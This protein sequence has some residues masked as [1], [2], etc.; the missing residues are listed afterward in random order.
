MTGWLFVNGVSKSNNL[1]ANIRNSV[2]PSLEGSTMAELRAKF[3]KAGVCSVA[4]P[5]PKGVSMLTY[6]RFTNWPFAAKVALAPVIGLAL[7]LVISMIT[8]QSL[9]AQSASIRV[10]IEQTTVANSLLTEASATIQ[11][12]NGDLYKVLTRT[13]A[14]TP[15]LNGEAEL[16]AISGRLDKVVALLTNFRDR[17]AD[18][19]EKSKI[20]DTIAAV[21]KYK[22]GFKFVS[23]MLDID[24]QSVVNFLDPFDKLAAGVTS[25]LDHIIADANKRSQL[26][27]DEVAHNAKRTSHVSHILAMIQ[28]IIV[29][30]ATVALATTTVRS[31]RRI[32]T[33]TE[34]LAQGDTSIDIDSLARRD[35]LGAIVRSL[36]TFRASQIQVKTLQQEQVEASRMAAE[37]RRTLMLNLADHFDQNVRSVVDAVAATARDMK[38][39]STILSHT[40]ADASREANAVAEVS[41]DATA[42][43]HSV[44]AASTQLS[45]SIAE[46]S[47]QVVNSSTIASNAV[48]EASS[49]RDQVQQL[50]AAAHKIGDIVALIQGIA[51]QTNLLALNATIEAARAGEAGRGFAV[52]AAEVKSLATE[53]SRATSEISSHVNEIQHATDTTVGAI[54]RIGATIGNMS[55]IAASIAA[56][57]EEQ[58]AATVEISR[59]AQQV[60]LA[61]EEVAQR[62]ISVSDA[63]VATGEASGGVLDASNTLA[64]QADTLNREVGEFLATVRA[65]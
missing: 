46:I 61:T 34:A 20:S 2:T 59:I 21:T 41:G 36:A 26:A 7:L 35:E 56:A 19:Q 48:E 16:A 12:A 27:A 60:A 24:F 63:A 55:E 10:L 50:A 47:R 9:R 28:G 54:D 22:S 11:S 65:A 39:S 23:Q 53:T 33:A 37:E 45:S 1:H 32:A 42:N 51:R 52:V 40:A 58:G 14:N 38:S 17:Y 18:D 4:T 8:D 5:Y 29:L 13:A 31:V 43:V 6:L 30:G 3:R 64:R 62:I 25:D 49:T 57:V 15:G 44:A